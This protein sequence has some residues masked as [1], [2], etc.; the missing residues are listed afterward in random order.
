M[1]CIRSEMASLPA[2]FTLNNRLNVFLVIGR[3]TSVRLRVERS[4]V[5]RTSGQRDP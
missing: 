4:A 5:R 1:S 3:R 2:K